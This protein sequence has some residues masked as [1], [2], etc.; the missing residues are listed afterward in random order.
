MVNPYAKGRPLAARNGAQNNIM[1]PQS[2]Q[3]VSNTKRAYQLASYSSSKKKRKGEQLT[4]QGEL[5]FVSERD[6]VVCRAQSLAKLTPN[7]R[8][9]KRSHHQLC[10]KNR[11]TKGKGVVSSQMI[12]CRAEEKRLQHLFSAPL[13]SHEKA[14]AVHLSKEGGVAFFQPRNPQ[15]QQQ[16]QQKEKAI[17]PSLAPAHPINFCAAVSAMTADPA[18]QEKHKKKGAPLAMIA[19]ASVVVKEV[20]RKQKCISNHFVGLTMTVPRYNDATPQCHSIMDQKLLLVDWAKTYGKECACPDAH[21]TGKLANERTNFSKNQTLFPIFGLDG[22]P[23]WC[24]AM[25]MICSKCKRRFDAND[26]EVLLALPAYVAAAYPVETKYA[27]S[28]KSSHL[29]KNATDV[30]D[31]IMLTHGNGDICSRL[32]YN[33]I[34]RKYL[35][36]LKIYYSY[37]AGN[38]S[39]T[40]P[41]ASYI[42]RKGQFIKTFPPL[43]DTIRD[44]YDE[45]CSSNNNPW[46]ISDHNRNTREIQAVECRGGIFAQD[47]TFEAVKNYQKSTGAK[48]V[49]D[50]ATHTGEI[51]AA[52]LVPS[53]KTKH[54]SHAARQLMNREGGR[55]TPRVMHSDTWPH[56]MEYWQKLVEGLEGRLGLFHFE[57]RILRT[58][59]K[60]HVDYQ[61]AVSDL[62]T[63]LCVCD[64]G[65]Y[66]KVLTALKDGTL[67]PTGHCYTEKEIADIKGTKVFR[68]R[69]NKYLRKKLWG[70][71]TMIQNLDDWF[72][73]YKVT[74]SDPEARPAGGRLDPYHGVPLFTNET[75]VAMENCKEKAKYI[76]DPLPIEEMCDCILPNPNSRH[77]LIEYLSRRGESKLESFH[78][79]FAN[80]ANSGMRTS[81]ADNL[82]LMG[83][84]RY[85]RAIRHKR[86]LIA[87][88]NDKIENPDIT[89]ERKRTPAAWEKVVPFDNHCE[90]DYI[91][92]LARGAGVEKVP[93]PNV[94][95]LPKDNRERFFSENLAQMQHSPW[96]DAH[97]FYLC[98]QCDPLG[99]KKRP[100]PLKIPPPLT[101]PPPP[102]TDKEGQLIRQHQARPTASCLPAVF[103]PPNQILPPPSMLY[104]PTYYPQFSPQAPQHYFTPSYCCEKYNLWLCRRVGRPPHDAHCQRRAAGKSN[105]FAII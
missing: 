54:F 7:Y 98:V 59:K 15:Q 10:I 77:Q 28:N 80:F 47:H 26:A 32:L 6:C 24:M 40:Q 3:R 101:P 72:C 51:A 90:L 81:L 69:Y 42:D 5:A 102:V 86:A 44:V 92:Q 57:K 70:P 37:N 38:N 1:G 95:V 89:A 62:L 65:D 74:S 66:E 48:A 105:E 33:S 73:K 58:L 60:K 23:A 35:E 20:I 91:N 67:S 100:P 22:A 2:Q 21:C 49:W 12:A 96:F 64:P 46:A 30:F 50:V 34:N 36:Q 76:T 83:T 53:T 78:D 56:K 55:F 27:L 84:A 13:D 39:S 29:H 31:S 88:R 16:Q 43:G 99:N 9:P 93:F 18:F 68:D 61:D 4:L 85:N 87:T 103:V 82:N 25:S 94:E 19:F 71:A 97:D 52:V 45:A 63:A 8:I 11:K 41:T 79:R 104:F 75:K 17:T 14:G